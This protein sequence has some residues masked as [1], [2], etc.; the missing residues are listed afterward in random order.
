MNR[1]PGEQWLLEQADRFN[2]GPPTASLDAVWLPDPRLLPRAVTNP[3]VRPLGARFPEWFDVRRTSEG[4][5]LAQ[6][7][8]VNSGYFQEY[9]NWAPFVAWLFDLTAAWIDFAAHPAFPADVRDALLPYLH[10]QVTI[11]TRLQ[12]LIRL[13]QVHGEHKG[14]SLDGLWKALQTNVRLGAVHRRFYNPFIDEPLEHI[15]KEVLNQQLKL[16]T[17]SAAAKHQARL[18]RQHPGAANPGA[19]TSG[20]RYYRPKNSKATGPAPPANP[21]PKPSA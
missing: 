11:T 17:K 2:D 18:D 21:P 19:S 8:G 16:A 14:T 9:Q 7:L 10:A 6:E 13:Q 20:G 5:Q 15:R 3:V 1:T 4:A 12:S